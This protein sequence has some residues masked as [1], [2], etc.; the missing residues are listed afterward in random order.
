MTSS[1][2][3]QTK[4]QKVQ[5]EGM[6]RWRDAELYQEGENPTVDWV[7]KGV[8]KREDQEPLCER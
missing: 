6:T 1:E 8:P 5:A 7:L 4:A 2:Q 3:P